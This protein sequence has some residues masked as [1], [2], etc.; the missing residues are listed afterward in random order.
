MRAER[1]GDIGMVLQD[2]R[3]N[4]MAVYDKWN[5]RAIRNRRRCI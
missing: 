5:I 3:G 2:I 1:E 4:K